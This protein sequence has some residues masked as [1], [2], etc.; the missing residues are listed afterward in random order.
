MT[1]FLPRWSKQNSEA[2]ETSL[3]IR[4]EKFQN[5]VAAFR[6]ATG[7]TEAREIPCRCAVT[8]EGFTI[9]FERLS[10]A[11]RFQIARIERASTA[12]NGNAFSGRFRRPSQQ[13]SYDAAEFDW[14]GYVCPHCRDQGGTVYCSQC[15]ETVCAGRVRAL[16]DGRNAFACHDGCG[17]TGATEPANLVH[18]GS[19]SLPSTARTPLLPPFAARPRLTYRPTPQPPGGQPE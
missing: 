1:N 10:P 4:R 15:R 9:V 11:H 13:K 5:E 6:T 16:P 8:G 3:A 17:A 2:R 18:G 19:A 14:T 12:G 7:K